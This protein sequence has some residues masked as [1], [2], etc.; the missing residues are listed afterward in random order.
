MYIFIYCVM[1]N[2]S[3]LT[4]M[5]LCLKLQRRINH[6]KIIYT[7]RLARPNRL[8]CI[9][10]FCFVKKKRIIYGRLTKTNESVL[11]R[12]SFEM[13]IFNII[14]FYKLFNSSTA[15]KIYSYSVERVFRIHVRLMI[16]LLNSTIKFLS[17]EYRTRVDI[18]RIPGGFLKNDFFLFSAYGFFLR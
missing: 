11:T 4:V 5:P 1:T 10:N 14:Y 18:N 13:K 15:L 2:L 9:C 6:V 16:S 8:L 12:R 7:T 17:R 3:L